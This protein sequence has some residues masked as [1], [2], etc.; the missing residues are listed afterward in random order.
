MDK[1]TIVQGVA[2]KLYTTESSLD[3]A[4]AD[5]SALLA[6]IIE[7]RKELK[8]ASTVDDAAV[9]KISEAISALTTARSAI[10]TAHGELDQIKLRLGVR[11]K[12]FGYYEKN[13]EKTSEVTA[14]RLAG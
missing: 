4:L 13:A 9:S 1:L 3:S 14:R 7:A 6:G 2:T 11:T 10:C 8:V 12:M 5:A